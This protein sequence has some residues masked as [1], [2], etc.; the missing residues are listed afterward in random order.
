LKEKGHWTYTKDFEA[1]NPF[2]TTT[3]L[4]GFVVLLVLEGNHKLCFVSWL[5]YR[6]CTTLS[7]VE[8]GVSVGI[9]NNLSRLIEE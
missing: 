4:S 2:Y 6:R 1:Y 7:V 5:D 8:Y 9:N 3:L